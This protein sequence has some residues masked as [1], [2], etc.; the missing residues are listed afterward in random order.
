M[1]DFSKYEASGNDFIVL[2][3]RESQF[4]F[5]FIQELAKKAC[6]RRFSIGSDGL[7]VLENSQKADVKMRIFNPDGSEVEM[8]GNGLRCITLFAKDLGLYKEGFEIETLAG[9]MKAY[10]NGTRVKTQFLSP[11]K[12]KLNIDL[13]IEGAD[14][15]EFHYINTGVP[16]VVSFVNDVNDVDVVNLGR[17]IRYHDK[18]KPEGTNANFVNVKTKNSLKIRTYERGVENETL[19][20][21]TGSMAAA[22]IGYLLKMVEAPVNLETKSGQ[23]LTVWFKEEN[24]KIFDLFIEGEVNLVYRGKIEIR[25]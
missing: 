13:F 14:D 10:I 25:K 19:A 8:C 3:N 24:A 15:Y 20:C 16:H 1:I 9:I 18:F 4:D 7:L 23:V 12:A 22:V 2:D 21:G 11:G 17:K 6:A 5:S